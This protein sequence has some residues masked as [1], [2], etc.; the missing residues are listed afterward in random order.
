MK[1][2]RP[3]VSIDTEATGPA[4]EF[5]R[6]IEVGLV[7][8]RP[9]GSSAE[10]R[11]LINPGR[12]IPAD[13]TAVHHITDA[14]VA[15]APRFEE[16][17]HAIA[18]ALRGCDLTGFNIRGF[19]LTILKREFERAHVAWPCEDAHVIDSFFI[20]KER[21]RHSL[22]H[23]V[24]RYC[25][26]EHV[27]AHTA[28]ADA[29][30]ALDVLLGQI[31]HYAD[32]RELDIAALDIAS[33]GRRPDWATELGH[34]RWREDGDLYI[35]FGKHEGKRLVDMDDGFLRWITGKDFPSDVKDL[36]WAVRRGDRPRAPGAPAL[37]EQRD[38]D[39]PDDCDDFFSVAEQEPV[40][41]RPAP[42]Q[43]RRLDINAFASTQPGD[44][45]IPF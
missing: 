39:D 42:A 1:L 20:F 44:D 40:G 30:G 25:G 37:P 14:D 13:A 36:V 35:A 27:D 5:D 12:P 38:S 6:V 43:A 17:A 26:R 3:L 2:L 11:W 18:E 45:D 4:P 32:L 21:E 31:E 19:D 23:A 34:L 28:V 10:S 9:D 33:G 41:L 8:L 15:A 24:R 16:V 22:A 7:T 29:Y